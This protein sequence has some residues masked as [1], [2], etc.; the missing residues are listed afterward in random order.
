MAR[1]LGAEPHPIDVPVRAAVNARY[2]ERWAYYRRRALTRPAAMILVHRL[3]D[4]VRR[5][6]YSLRDPNA[7]DWSWADS[8]SRGE[9]AP[10]PAS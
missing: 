5:Y 4:A 9:V 8:M 7:V 2:L 10:T 1:F 6:G 3:E